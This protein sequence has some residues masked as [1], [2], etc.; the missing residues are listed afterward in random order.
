MHIGDFVAIVNSSRDTIRYYEEL[1]LINPIRDGDKRN[2]TEKDIRDFYAIKELESLGFTV[3][4]I[5]IIFYINR[6]DD[7]RYAIDEIHDKMYSIIRTIEKTEK[8]LSKRK[9]K[10]YAMLSKLESTENEKIMR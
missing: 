4:E 10:L 3:S 2:Y 5:Q 6:S 1:N 9:M 8:E 7:T